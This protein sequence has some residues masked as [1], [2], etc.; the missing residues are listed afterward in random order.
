[1]NPVEQKSSTSQEV[2]D[3][4]NQLEQLIAKEQDTLASLETSEGTDYRE[5]L[6]TGAADTGVVEKIAKANA[7]LTVLTRG[8]VCA[9]ADLVEALDRE[10]VQRRREAKAKLM[11]KFERGRVLASKVEVM[12][13]EM[14]KHLIELSNIQMISAEE[15]MKVKKTLG[16][17]L[18]GTHVMEGRKAMESNGV[19]SRQL[20]VAFF[21][22]SGLMRPDHLPNGRGRPLTEQI[23]Q[24]FDQAEQEIDVMLGLDAE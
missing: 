9:K 23:N 8:L 6:A 16:V 4:I 19:L 18:E 11:E 24:V 12:V 3:S 13:N 14:S 15:M 7:R 21:E 17:Q 20:Q 10:L 22:K 2:A 5:L 1:M